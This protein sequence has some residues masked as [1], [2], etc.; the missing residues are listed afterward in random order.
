M[1]SILSAVKDSA[2]GQRIIQQ[3]TLRDCFSLTASEHVSLLTLRMTRNYERF[4]VPKLTKNRIVFP[5]QV[6]GIGN[7]S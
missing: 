7:W 5:F 6:V 2:L 4:A 1:L 3:E